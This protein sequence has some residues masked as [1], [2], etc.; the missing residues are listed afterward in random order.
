[1]P[2][3]VVFKLQQGAQY[4]CQLYFSEI[5]KHVVSETSAIIISRIIGNYIFPKILAVMIFGNVN[6]YI[7]RKWRRMLTII[8]S[9]SLANIIFR[10]ASD[11]C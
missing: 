4:F 1:M 5:L 2:A 7:F 11:K 3:N 10:S 8:F 6:N 9:K